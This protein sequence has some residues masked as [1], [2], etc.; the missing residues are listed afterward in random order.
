VTRRL[1]AASVVAAALLVAF[2]TPAEARNGRRRVA[3]LEHRTGV[4]RAADL[5]ARMAVVLARSAALEVVSPEEARRRLQGRL[6]AMIARC[7]GDPTCVA[8][9]GERIHVDEVILV[10]ISQLGDVI[11]AL[12]RISVHTRAV[13]G[14]I[15]EALPPGTEPG[16]ETLLSYLRRLLPPED[17]RRY[18]GIRVKA[19]ISGAEIALDGQV[20]GRTPLANLQVEAPRRYELTVRKP[21]YIDFTAN[22]DV[23]PDFTVEV[24][25]DLHRRPG[26]LAW[27]QRWWVWGIA[28]AVAAG[29][30]TALALTLRPS[31]NHDVTVWVDPNRR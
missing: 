17:F 24:T 29:T 3:I 23:Q 30:A 10:G 20:R 7:A 31:G 6:D 27:Y 22:L 25:P 4:T 2:V 18:G 13:E 26:A 16:D 19:S 12:Q 21:G 14:R 9:V 28:A 8:H 11:L 15:A 5:A 1:A